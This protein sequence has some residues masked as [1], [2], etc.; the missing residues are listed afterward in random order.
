[1]GRKINT[2][3][4]LLSRTE[5]T[6]NGCWLWTG[7]IH[8]KTGYG[9]LQ[10]DYINWLAHRY[11]FSIL[12]QPIPKGKILDHFCN[13]RACVNPKHL[14]ISTHQMNNTRSTISVAGINARKTHCLRGHKFTE[15]NIYR[16]PQRGSRHCKKC[17]AFRQK[18]LLNRCRTETGG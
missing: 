4:K 18:Q 10:C 15:S 16:H 7:K 9:Y 2:L 11:F 1:M 13:V 8:K 12:K 3:K 17:N 5:K 6:P 14:K